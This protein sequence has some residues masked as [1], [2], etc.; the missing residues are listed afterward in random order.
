MGSSANA[1]PHASWRIRF[2]VITST[3]TISPHPFAVVVAI[4]AGL[5]LVADGSFTLSPHGHECIPGFLLL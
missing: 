2:V 5:A 3:I 1:T 4:T